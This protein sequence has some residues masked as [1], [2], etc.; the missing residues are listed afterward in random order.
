M[1]DDL[2]KLGVLLAARPLPDD[3]DAVL[4]AAAPSL[5]A[6]ARDL[7]ELLAS[8][9]HC[10]WKAPELDQYGQRVFCDRLAMCGTLSHEPEWCDEHRAASHVRDCDWADIIRRR[11][12]R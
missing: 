4:I 2:D 5:L 7:A 6:S 3:I 8:L 9:P 10:R 12:A 1:N 11:D